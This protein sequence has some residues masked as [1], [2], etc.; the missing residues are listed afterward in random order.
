LI[1][2][3]KKKKLLAYLFFIFPKKI[4]QGAFVSDIYFFKMKRII[5]EAMRILFADSTFQTRKLAVG[6]R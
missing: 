5:D 3:Y 4:R 6:D 1:Y 2:N